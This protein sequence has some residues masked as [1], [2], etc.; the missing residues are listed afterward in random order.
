MINTQKKTKRDRIK[1]SKGETTCD[2]QIMYSISI[3]QMS[4]LLSPHA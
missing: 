4:T 1:E 3:M 2:R